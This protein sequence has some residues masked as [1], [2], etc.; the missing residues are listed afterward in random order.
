[1]LLAAASL[2]NAVPMTLKDSNGT[3]YNVN[4]QVVPLN[5][6]SN[7][8]GALTDA[9]FLKPVTVTVYYVGLTPWFGFL[10]T[11]TTQ[12]QVNVPLK[13]AFG[14]HSVDPSIGG[15]NSLLITA[16][17]G[18]KLAA[19]LVF[20]PG[21]ALAGQDCPDSNG[22]NKQLDFASQTFAA[23][24]LTLTRKVYVPSGQDWARWLNIVTNTGSAPAQVTIVLLGLIG[25]GSDT[26][27]VT[28]SSGDNSL[29]TGDFW[30]TTAQT[31]PQG[32]TSFQP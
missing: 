9:T 3:A 24:N 10:T 8:S 19:P 12:H 2:A 18:Q 5:A 21:Q 26:Y 28:T 11:Y 23:Q 15:L 7:A 27:V 17:N 22:K 30:F 14:D 1:A 6:L 16:V 4:T 25:S 29:T 31:V 20:N 32:A 13:P